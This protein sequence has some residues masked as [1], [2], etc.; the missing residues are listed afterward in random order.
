MN[1]QDCIIIGAGHAGITLAFQLRREGWVGGI[2][3][4]SNEAQLPYHR[5]PL[6]KE[7]LAG[8][9]DL[10]SI[11]LRPEKAYLDNAIE[12]ITNTHVTAI[13]KDEQ[14]IET[15]AGQRLAYSKLALC[16]GADARQ[17]PQLLTATN[18][19]TIR[20]AS[21]I[22]AM[23]AALANG[24]KRVVIVGGGYIGLEAA[25]VLRQLNCQVTVVEA[26]QRL[27]ERVTGLE[28][29][30]FMASLH[31][32]YAVDI[33]TSTLV[34]DFA[35]D[36]SATKVESV[37]LSNG[38]SLELD[39]LIVGIGA[40]PSVNLATAAGLSVANGIIVNERCETSAENIYAAGDCS[41]HPSNYFGSRLRLESVQN[42]ND[43]ARAA[44]ANI[45]GKEQAYQT[46]PWFWSDQY[47]VKLQM[48]G[49]STGYDQVIAR[50]LEEAD[51]LAF[52]TPEE[53]RGLAQKGF[54]LFYFSGDKLLA[55]DAVNRPKEFMV[56]KQL[57]QKG[58]SVNKASLADETV[59]PKELL[60]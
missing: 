18:A 1:N 10:M 3:V 17:L 45:A 7:L 53:I 42:A 52:A 31:R 56:A 36:S 46:I 26:T 34:E 28:M 13:H 23:K 5:P 37:R 19:F 16:T 35:F 14:E 40:I 25:A 57:L 51:K 6:S 2:K 4:I 12:L 43:Q 24:A 55:A 33:I 47:D 49:L 60:A 15:A 59:E 27:L 54:A 30:L 9:K 32:A 11:A 29:S 20:Q 48:T 38:R 44:A 39:M 41:N 58:L 21:D 8:K 50:G 22:D